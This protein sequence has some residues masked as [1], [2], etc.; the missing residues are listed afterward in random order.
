MTT[1]PM[2]RRPSAG[3]PRPLVAIVQQGVWAMEKECQQLP[4]TER[5]PTSEI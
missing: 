4:K 2:P 5:G 3:G 1:V